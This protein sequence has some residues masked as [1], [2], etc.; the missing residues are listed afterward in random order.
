MR[1]K[2]VIVV[3]W[4][5]RILG[6]HVVLDLGDGVYA[7]FAHLKHRWAVVVKGQRVR[8]GEQLASYGNSG[9]STEPHLHFQLTDRPGLLTGAGLPFRGEE[10]NPI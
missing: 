7:A 6:N 3:A 1:S 5:G 10:H 8:P 2:I 9:N 4:V